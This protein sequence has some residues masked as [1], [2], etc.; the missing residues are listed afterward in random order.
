[1]SL[2]GWSA[3]DLVLFA[4]LAYDV[5]GYYQ[6]APQALRQSLQSFQYIAQHLEEL[7]DVLK[8]SDWPGYDTAPKLKDD[9]RQAKH[10]FE[11]YAPLSTATTVSTSRLSD[12]AGSG[13]GAIEG[14]LREIDENLEDHM[15]KMNAFKQQVIL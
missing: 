12:T 1:M 11:N 14:K 4:K 10:F 6:S 8:K 2:Y 13:L 7:S 9:L 3:E 5:F 15:D